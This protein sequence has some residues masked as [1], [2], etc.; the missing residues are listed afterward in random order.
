[1]LIQY[2][3]QQKCLAAFKTWACAAWWVASD[4]L[5]GSD[6]GY[7]CGNVRSGNA[8]VRGTVEVL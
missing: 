6:G 4:A 3:K 2:K 7:D 8:G 5:G 1:M